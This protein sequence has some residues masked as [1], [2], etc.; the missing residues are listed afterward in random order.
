MSNIYRNIFYAKGL[1]KI[2]DGKDFNAV[3]PSR[4]EE[5]AQYVSSYDKTGIYGWRYANW[6]CDGRVYC[7]DTKEDTTIFLLTANATPMLVAKK[8]SE[9]LG[10]EELSHEFSDQSNGNYEIFFFK[11]KSGEIVEATLS[12]QVYDKETDKVEY[13]TCE[14]KVTDRYKRYEVVA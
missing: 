10:D 6:G 1:T 8:L 13:K 7:A 11:W 4:P 12:T 3:I 5:Y 14:I 9:M 2:W